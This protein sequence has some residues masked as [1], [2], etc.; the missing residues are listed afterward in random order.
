MKQQTTIARDSAALIQ[1]IRAD[2]AT[3]RSAFLALLDTLSDEEWKSRSANRAWKIGEMMAHTTQYIDVA[4]PMLVKNARN[5]KTMSLPP[6][7]A[8]RINVMLT[9]SYARKLTRQSIAR[10]YETAHTAALAL[11]EGVQDQEWDLATCFPDGERIT[12]EG[13]FRHHAHHF[14]EHAQQVQQGLHRNF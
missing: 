14:E 11:L 8:N 10:R 9:R 1:P 6:F 4:L 7:L 3:T 5:R 13:L 2:L 12:I